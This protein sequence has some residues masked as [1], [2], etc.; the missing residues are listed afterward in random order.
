M[1]T[2]SMSTFPLSPSSMPPM[3][4]AEREAMYQEWLYWQYIEASYERNDYNLSF[5]SKFYPSA[6]AFISRIPLSNSGLKSSRSMLL[7][8]LS[9]HISNL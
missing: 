4:E 7:L 8:G 1:S 3:A 2:T 6:Y 9:K 5:V